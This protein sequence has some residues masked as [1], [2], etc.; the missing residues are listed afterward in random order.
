MSRRAVTVALLS[1]TVPSCCV[2]DRIM[3][4]DGTPCSRRHPDFSGEPTKNRIPRLC[5]LG[6]MNLSKFLNFNQIWPFRRPHMADFS[7]SGGAGGGCL[8]KA[9]PGAGAPGS[10]RQ[11]RWLP[12]DSWQATGSGRQKL[13]LPGIAAMA[14]VATSRSC[15]PVPDPTPTPPMQ[16]PST[17]IGNPPGRLIR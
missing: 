13:W 17:T 3:I 14:S 8:V 9:D 6:V 1:L 16:W 2:S 5:L 11:H 10:C 15:S 7:E 12:T 4:P